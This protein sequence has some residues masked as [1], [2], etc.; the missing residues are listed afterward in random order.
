M[1]YLRDYFYTIL[2]LW[3]AAFAV[4]DSVL[5]FLKANFSIAHLLF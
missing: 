5:H 2:F 4:Y 3:F 1:F